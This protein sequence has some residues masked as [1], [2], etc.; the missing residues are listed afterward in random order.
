MANLTE[1]DYLE[2]TV[3][4]TYGS[5]VWSHKIQEKQADMYTTRYR[6]M[7]TAKIWA[8]SLTS[9]GI[10]SLVFTDA[11]WVKLFS[12]CISFVSIFVSAFFKSFDLKTM[13]SAH[14]KSA[15]D[16]LAIRDELITLILQIRMRKEAPDVLLAEYEELMGSLHKVYAEAPSTTDKAVEDARV[17]LNIQKDNTF[18]DE[19]IDSYLPE[20]LRK[21]DEPHEHG[22]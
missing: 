14:K 22:G 1:Y 2:S 15:V 10:V 5:V 12:A 21:A 13:I 20:A 11:L 9:A 8:A 19:E 17:A 16:I 3:R 7:E 4:N 6:R 18:S